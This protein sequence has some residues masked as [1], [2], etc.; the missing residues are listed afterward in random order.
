MLLIVFMYIA[1][2]FSNYLLI[3]YLFLLFLLL[4][5]YI[6]YKFF[7]T[8]LNFG[9]EEKIILSL[10]HN[11]EYSDY[12][13]MIMLEDQ[14]AVKYAMSILLQEYIKL[15]KK[16]HLDNVEEIG[17]DI[18]FNE[19]DKMKCLAHISSFIFAVVFMCT[20]YTSSK[21]VLKRFNVEFSTILNNNI[22]IIVIFIATIIIFH[23][24][25]FS[26]KNIAVLYG[27]CSFEFKYKKNKMHLG[28]QDYKYKYNG[29]NPLFNNAR[30]RFI[31]TCKSI[32][33]LFKIAQKKEKSQT[34]VEIC[35]EMLK[36][37]PQV[38]VLL[39]LFKEIDSDN[40][41][42][43]IPKDVKI[44]YTSCAQAVLDSIHNYK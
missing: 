18:N 7:Q 5:F 42:I 10:Y 9:N 17:F 15:S 36:E 39:Y 41:N 29:T 4:F 12:D 2:F 13:A 3:Q 20:W 35:E 26:A 37:N 25:C 32:Y 1:M 22:I 11:I 16:I 44:C 19:N 6:L 33:V 34:L 30:I 27:F 14:D 43:I 21:F 24:K 23:L 31:N 38:V 28:H 8:I 40:A